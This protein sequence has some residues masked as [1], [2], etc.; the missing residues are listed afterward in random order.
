MNTIN[1]TGNVCHDLELKTTQTGKSVTQLNLAVKRPFSTDVTDFIPLVVWNQ[2]A[3]YLCKFARKGSKIAVS[4][5]LTTRKY[6]DKDGNN[7]TAFEVVCDVVEILDSKA[8]GEQPQGN[9]TENPK[10]TF[11]TPTP[12]EFVAFNP[13]DDLPF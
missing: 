6:Q 10:P 1:L 13:D 7:R 2:P 9:V 12:A 11:T 4:D 3:E 5:K 8:S